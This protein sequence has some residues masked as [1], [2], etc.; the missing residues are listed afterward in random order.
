MKVLLAILGFAILSVVALIAWT[1]YPWSLDEK[2]SG[3]EI[4]AIEPDHMV[5]LEER[6][7]VIK[8][9]TWNLGFL[10]GEGSE[11]PGYSY[12]EKNYFE[13][14]MSQLALEI[15][16]RSPDVICLQEVDFSSHRSH[17]LNQAT[18]LAR[19]T[20]YPYVALAPSWVA[21]YIPFPYMPLK[22][23]FGSMNS[24]GAILSRYPIL[25]Q[26]VTLLKKPMSNP[27]WYNLFYLHRY[28]QKVE[29]EYGDK[30]F[31]IINLHLEAFDKADRKTQIQS[32][33]EMVKGQSI[34]FITGDFNMVPMIATKKSKFYNA[35]EYE[36]DP[37]A[38][39]MKKSGLSEVIPD[40]IYAKEESLYFTFPSWK[41]DRRLDYIFYRSG[42]KMM[43]AEIFTS[44][45]SDHLPLGASF[46]IDSPR[47]NPYSQ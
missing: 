15:R 16:E 2:K 17:Y 22:N 19:R 38:E 8:I 3:G 45:L 44:A 4:V 5:D 10:Y 12:R 39:L 18:D 31:K 46:Q 13:D 24:G 25:S 9:M 33:L 7:S 29:I 37:S 1:S 26:E 28:F 43:K 23:N 21:N 30:K 34:D 36:D 47:F 32:L 27:W 14:R 11:G 41:P 40:D 6:P 20:G 42:L 35:D